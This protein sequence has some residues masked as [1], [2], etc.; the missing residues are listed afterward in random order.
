MVRDINSD[1]V[2]KSVV[3]SDGTRIGRVT[4]VNDGNARVDRD[5]D[6]DLTDKVKSMLGWGDSDDSHEVRNEHVDRIDDDR[7]HLR[8]K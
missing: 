1:D 4:N 7:I 8:N 2:D 6:A 3:T 5:D